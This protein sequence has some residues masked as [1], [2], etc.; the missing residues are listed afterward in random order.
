MSGIYCPKSK[1][2]KT[3][4]KYPSVHKSNKCLENSDEKFGET[5]VWIR[6]LG[7]NRKVFCDLDNFDEFKIWNLAFLLS[8][9]WSLNKMVFE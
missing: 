4:F 5:K 2:M 1:M 8:F 3:G 7:D 9:D 6:A